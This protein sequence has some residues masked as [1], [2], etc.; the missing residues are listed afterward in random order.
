MRIDV[1]IKNILLRLANKHNTVDVFDICKLEGIQVIFKDYNPNGIKARCIKLYDEWIIYINSN[2]SLKSQY[3]LCA[4]EL[5]HI[6]LHPDCNI[7]NFSG[8][9]YELEHEANLF[10][11]YFV[12]DENLYDLKFSSMNSYLLSAV[13]DSNIK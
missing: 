1:K 6:M 2:F 12:L 13:I 7:N 5:G 8:C 11:A 3:I 9:D 10:A 4:H